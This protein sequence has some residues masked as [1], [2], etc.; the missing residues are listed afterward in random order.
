MNKLYNAVIRQLGQGYKDDLKNVVEHGA[1]A[2]FNGF[3][4]YSDTV[5]F[6]KRN[7]GAIM[8]RLEDVRDSIGA[9]SLSSV[10][11]DFNCVDLEQHEVEQALLRRERDS[12]WEQVAD[13]LAKFA[14]EEVAYECDT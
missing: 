6:T 4:Y 12:N 1:D 8:E 7:Y 3:I 5:A 11:A 13:A 10:I 2:G 9:S 14:L